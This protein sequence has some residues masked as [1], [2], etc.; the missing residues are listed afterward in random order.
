[1]SK[2]L[3]FGIITIQRLPWQEEVQRWKNIEAILR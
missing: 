3:R 2:E 1:M